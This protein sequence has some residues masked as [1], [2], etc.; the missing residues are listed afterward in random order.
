[1][2]PRAARELRAY[3]SAFSRAGLNPPI[4]TSTDR[5]QAEQEDL[6]RRGRGV[7]VSKHVYGLAAD[8]V[9]ARDWRSRV[10]LTALAGNVRLWLPHVEAIAE[11]DHV[12]IEW[13]WNFA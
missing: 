3:L 1:M 8:I 4:V 11:R 7:P 2:N 6:L 10:S 5:T 9:Q 12:H 13:P